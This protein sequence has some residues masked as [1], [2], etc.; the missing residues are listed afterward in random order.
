[1]QQIDAIRRA[2]QRQGNANHL[3]LFGIFVLGALGLGV[4]NLLLLVGLFT[5]MNRL[6][7]KAP[8]SL[9]QTVDGRS[10][11]TYA[12]ESKDRTPI[13]IRRFTIDTMTMLL[14]ASGKLPGT[15]DH[16]NQTIDAGV[17]IK[18][19]DR[20]E[21]R[22]STSTWQSSFALSAD[23]RNAALQGIS[24]LMPPDAF[25]GHAQVVLV[26]QTV[27]DPEKIGEGQWKVKMIANLVT[28][29]AGNPEGMTIPFN[30]EIFLR[31]IDTPPPNEVT[32]PLQ[33]AV[34]QIRS[35]GLEIYGM[36][37]YTPGNLQK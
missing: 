20:T 35:S 17:A 8:P 1:M 12:M 9:V 24:E 21:R 15:P 23:F 2:K 34:Y 36:R 27:S 37:D 19:P 28:I 22:V 33:K 3:N 11:V 25:T 18:L 31:A 30:K 4:L 6:S 29:S 5:S 26:P 14:S 32:T 16:P 7:R 10:I 13:V